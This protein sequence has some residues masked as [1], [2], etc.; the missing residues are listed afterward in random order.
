MHVNITHKK[1]LVQRA[2]NLFGN[3][4][5]QVEEEKNKG[6][7]SPIENDLDDLFELLEYLTLRNQIKARSVANI[8]KVSLA[9]A[10]NVS[11]SSNPT[12]SVE[13]EF[14]LPVALIQLL[15][16]VLVFLIVFF[17]CKCNQMMEWCRDSR[18]RRRLERKRMRQLD[19][20]R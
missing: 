12:H 5:T 14:E 16:I 13:D 19:E 8:S 9:P 4:W 7:D 2:L 1:R 3:R 20:D 18:R 15:I 11:S 6:S 17:M 10:S